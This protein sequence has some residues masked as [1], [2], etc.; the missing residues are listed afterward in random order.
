MGGGALLVIFVA[1]MEVALPWP[2]KIIVDDVLQPL[3]KSGH[4]NDAGV[5]G[6]RQ[7]Q[8]PPA[9]AAGRIGIARPDGNEL[10]GGLPGDPAAQRC[11]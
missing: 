6:P 2:M 9:A 1:A 4:G 3:G 8:P 11:R 7:P 5:P 10:S